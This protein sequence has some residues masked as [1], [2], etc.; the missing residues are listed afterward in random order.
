MTYFNNDNIT[1]YRLAYFNVNANWLI[2]GFYRLA[3]LNN[4]TKEN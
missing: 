4:D 3:Y 2:L 1:I